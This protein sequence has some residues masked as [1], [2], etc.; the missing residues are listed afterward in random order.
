VI[1][2]AVS[3]RRMALLAP[4]CRRCRPW[5][6]AC[7]RPVTGGARSR[8]EAPGGREPRGRALRA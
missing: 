6:A 4:V 5:D 2:S 1:R 7:R 8:Y 3:V